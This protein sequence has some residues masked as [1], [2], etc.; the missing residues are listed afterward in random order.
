ML[1]VAMTEATGQL[2]NGQIFG[3]YQIV[4]ILG[5]GG[6][7]TVYEAV[8]TGIKKRVAIKTLL[9]ALSRSVEAQTRFL[10]E[11]E[12]AS[13][14]N[15]PNVVNVTDVGS[16]GGIPYL[17]MEY[18]E[19][20]TL[21]D[22][23]ARKGSLELTEALDVFLPSLA[24]VAVGHDQGVIHR[25]L[26]PQNIFIA[27]GAGHAS[28]P[29]VLDFGVSKIIGDGNVA[30]TGTMAV[31]GTAAYMSPEQARGAK[32]IDAAS[33]QYAMGLILHEMVTGARGHD[34]DSPLEVLHRI[35]SGIV[36]DTAQLC[37]GLPPNV[38][39]LV[40]RMLATDP[41]QRF[42]SLRAVARDLLPHATQRMR[43]IYDDS[44]RDP[45]ATMPATGPA[46]RPRAVGPGSGAKSGGTRLLPSSG[47]AK[48]LSTSTLGQ[49][50]IDLTPDLRRSRWTPVWIVCGIAAA[51]VAGFLMLGRDRG[52]EAHVDGP[53][54]TASPTP[55]SPT[56]ASPAPAAELP[57][58]P[59]PP[60]APVLPRIVSVPPP[61]PKSSPAI[62][63][64]GPTHPRAKDTAAARKELPKS[65]PHGKTKR[66]GDSRKMDFGS[67]ES[68][69]VD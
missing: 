27:Q 10:R 66:G 43:L 32:V 34:G 25:D 15:H 8:H 6:M 28:I 7:G 29:K 40:R 5:E 61:A 59:P 50:A 11:G 19:G 3:R 38:L 62:E 63:P 21:A 47:A 9:P 1:G 14:I 30:L 24:A 26:K 68:P 42:S 46:V 31:L 22:L 16:E 53:S 69:I 52:G 18:L 36:P 55:E 60:V 58:T 35:A 48:P 12:A 20:E 2:T 44:F 56:P 17:V 23:I 57:K 67:N 4:R 54:P 49:S 65:S 13:R 51:G 33:D 64:R 39:A 37:P 41:R 45:E